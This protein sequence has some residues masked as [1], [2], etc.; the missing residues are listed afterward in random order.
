MATISTP[1]SNVPSLTSYITTGV[2]AGVISGVLNVIVLYVG[3]AMGITFEIIGQPGMPLTAL[4]FMPVFMFSLVPAIGAAFLAWGLNR[5]VPRGNAI[6]IGI[7]IAFLL[8]SFIPDLTM[9]DPV[10]NGTRYGLILMHIVAGA[11]ITYMLARR[12]A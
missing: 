8:V 5:Y 4:D 1:R 10:T 12:A 3:K 2:I 7:A 11:V 6:F 9:P